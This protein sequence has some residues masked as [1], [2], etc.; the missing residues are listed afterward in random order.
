MSTA[1]FTYWIAYFK[2]QH[3]REEAERLRTKVKNNLNKGQF[4]H[5]M[6]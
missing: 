4:Q 1:E 2:R 6:D 3:E 5:S